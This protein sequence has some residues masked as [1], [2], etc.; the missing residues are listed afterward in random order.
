MAEGTFSTKRQMECVVLCG[1]HSAGHQ[2]GSRRSKKGGAQVSEGLS[3]L[4]RVDSIE[5]A[6][7]TASERLGFICK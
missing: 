4:F 3:D 1:N 6:T 7:W 2:A 5:A